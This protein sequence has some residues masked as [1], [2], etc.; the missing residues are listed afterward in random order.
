VHAALRTSIHPAEPEVLAALDHFNRHSL[1]EQDEVS[2]LDRAECKY[3][4]PVDRLPSLISELSNDYTVLQCNDDWLF[5]YE[6]TYF[7]TGD[8]Q[9]YRQHHNGKLNRYK[10]RHRRYHET[11]VSFVEVKSKNNKL[12]TV[13]RRIPWEAQTAIQVDGLDEGLEQK[14]YVNYRRASLWNRAVNERITLDFDLYFKRFSQSQT[15]SLPH[16]AVIELKCAGKPQTSPFF[17]LAGARHLHPQPMSKYCV[18]ACL[19]DD[20]TLKTNRFR[21]L[22]KTVQFENL[23]LGRIGS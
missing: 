16:A 13:K 23:E 19:T 6:N 15:V 1:A 14:L 21:R 5:T 18:G 20:G 4:M 2:L 7:D 10:C 12:R 11:N 8:W 9:L 17:R 3:L 22:L